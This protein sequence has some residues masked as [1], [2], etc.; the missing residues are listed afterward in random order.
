MKYRL[1]LIILKCTAAAVHAASRG[2]KTGV[3]SI[4]HDTWQ[5][6]NFHEHIYIRYIKL[7]VFSCDHTYTI[8]FPKKLYSYLSQIWCVCVCL[9]LGLI[10]LHISVLDLFK[11]LCGQ[12]CQFNDTHLVPFYASEKQVVPMFIFMENLPILNLI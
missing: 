10:E 3:Q 8:T 6:L 7:L 9:V 4:Y 12:L 5:S 11:G 2:C 1:Q